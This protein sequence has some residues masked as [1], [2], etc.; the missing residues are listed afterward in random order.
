MV[1]V[2]RVCHGPKGVMEHFLGDNANNAEIPHLRNQQQW[3]ASL[4]GGTPCKPRLLVT[5]CE[6]AI[7]TVPSE[8]TCGRRP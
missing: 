2:E 4:E 1:D 8:V 7:S 6:S 5:T 3:I